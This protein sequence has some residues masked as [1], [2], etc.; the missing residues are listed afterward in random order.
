MKKE[1][2]AIQWI[3]A[4]LYLYNISTNVHDLLIDLKRINISA[5]IPSVNEVFTIPMQLHNWSS[6]PHIGPGNSETHTVKQSV[7]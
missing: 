5:I 7:S 6:W 4:F 3:F 2:H 1:I